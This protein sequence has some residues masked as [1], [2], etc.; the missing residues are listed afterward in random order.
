MER[1]KGIVNCTVCE[2]KGCSQQGEFILS[3][4]LTCNSA[5]SRSQEQGRRV[6]V[7]SS[8]L[9]PHYEFQTGVLTNMFWPAHEII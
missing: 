6:C 5:Q 1:V 4:R 7:W 3:L 8:P 2:M 9:A